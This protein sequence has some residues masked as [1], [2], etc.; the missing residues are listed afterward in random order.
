[1]DMNNKNESVTVAIPKTLHTQLKV[2]AAI[3]QTTLQEHV[4]SILEKREYA[5]H[6]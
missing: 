4:V 6:D 5:K 3:K 1:M 2:E